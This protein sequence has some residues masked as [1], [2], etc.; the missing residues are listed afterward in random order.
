M[1]I[2]PPGKSWQYDHITCVWCEHNFSAH[3]S[4]LVCCVKGCDCK[5]LEMKG[6]LL[7]QQTMDV[8]V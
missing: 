8:C 5:H 2:Q 6:D 1:R 4:L 3:N 7:D